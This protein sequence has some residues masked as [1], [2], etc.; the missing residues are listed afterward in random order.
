MPVKGLFTI[1]AI[2]ILTYV[3]C[4]AG[5]QT[6]E[7]TGQEP[8]PPPVDSTQPPPPPPPPMVQRP[9]EESYTLPP[10][11]RMS[12]GGGFSPLGIGMQVSTDINE[13]L[14]LR[15]TGNVFRLNTSF[16]VSGV[17]SSA[18]VNLSSAGALLDAYPFH[19]GWRVSGGILYI[20]QNEINASANVPG[21]DSFTLNDQT[22]YSA[23]QNT[24]TGA[25]PLSGR[26]SLRLNEMKPGFI[27][28]TGWGNHVRRSGHWT[29]PFEIGVAF[30]GEPKVNMAVSGWACTDAAQTACANVNDATNPLAMQF[31]GNL[32][33]QISKWNSDLSF[34][35]S[36]PFITT[37]IAYSFNI[38]RH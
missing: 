14:N 29:V 17:P 1:G 33:T 16:D 20:N 9:P 13:H 24:A 38:R 23:S 21:G 28:S 2:A 22:Y 12:I 18:N 35:R 25:T 37:G 26:G 32:I 11:S 31:Q 5:A 36:Y 3:S 6:P 7:G 15:A 10:F 8:P 34:L 19:V 27:L 30:V 4:A